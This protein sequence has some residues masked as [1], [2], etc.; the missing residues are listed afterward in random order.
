[1]AGKGDERRKREGEKGKGGERKG[2]KC[3]GKEVRGGEG[4]Q[5]KFVQSTA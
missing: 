2:V 4:P 5:T 1:M 3:E